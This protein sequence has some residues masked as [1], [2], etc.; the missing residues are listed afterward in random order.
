MYSKTPTPSELV[1]VDPVSQFKQCR[2]CA[3]VMEGP[4]A[5]HL[6][7]ACGQPQPLGDSGDFFAAFGVPRKF[8]QDS[9]ALEK[10]FYE[11]S[12][13]LHPDRFVADRPDLKR[14]SLERMS[15]INQAYS[16]LKNPEAL[17]EYLLVLEDVQLDGLTVEKAQIPMELAESW[18]D[19]QDA[20]SE[21][22]ED[23]MA[24]IN[25]FEKDLLER[26]EVLDAEILVLEDQ[27]DDSGARVHLLQIAKAIQ[28][29][30][31]LQSLHRDVLKIKGGLS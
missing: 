25:S 29:Q 10:R 17:R 1:A 13:F 26:S 18:F 15:L 20:I 3:K 24:E 22:S 23:L 12:R 28:S 7:A 19:L 30:S 11:L 9:Q 21:S 6:C 4:A 2:F 16:A 27:Y 8:H 31:Y 14:L 5:P